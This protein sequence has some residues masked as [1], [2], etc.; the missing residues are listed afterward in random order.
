MDVVDLTRSFVAIDS[1]NP[2]PG[3]TAMAD[4]VEELVSRS[5]RYRVTRHELEPGRPNLIVTVGEGPGPHLA[6]SGHLD[7]KPVGDAL[8]LWR[9]DPFELTIIDGLAYGLGATDMKGAVAAM[10]IAL[11]RYAASGSPAPASLIL[12]ADEEQ[13]SDAGAK[14]LVEHG[15]IDV[16]GIVIGEPSGVAHSWEMLALASRGICCFEVTVTTMQGHSGLSEHLGRNAVLVAA[17]VLRAFESFEP[18]IDAPGLVPSHVTVNSGILARGGVAFG[19]SPG[20]CTVGV[21]LRLA[22]GMSRESV[23]AAVERT[24]A[25]AVG[26]QGT[27]A[28][29]YRDGSL[30]WMP[31]TE[32]DPASPVVAAAQ[33]ACGEVLGKEL[34]PRAY[35]GGTD[36]TY[37]M[38]HGGVPTVTSLGPGLLSVAHGPN[39]YVPV[40]DLH[41]AVDLYSALFSTFARSTTP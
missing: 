41:T 9:T 13:G 27:Y 4:A 12:T 26:T 28:I 40:T 7:T 39:E 8:S 19:T 22:P 32:L 24:V 2:G 31:A 3:E 18:P 10:L 6:L 14:A 30:G 1:Q 35:P 5:G 33:Q 29:A 25:S 36:A 15:L 38:G 34:P 21:E 16:D 37:F 23:E 11:D 17:D 20:E